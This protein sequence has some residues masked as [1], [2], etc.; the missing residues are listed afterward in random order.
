[1]IKAS[2]PHGAQFAAI[3]MSEFTVAAIAQQLSGGFTVRGR[4]QPWAIALNKAGPVLAEFAR[5]VLYLSREEM[6]QTASLPSPLRDRRVESVPG[7]PGSDWSHER[8]WRI[9]W[10]D[11][12]A[13]PGLNLIPG[14]VCS[15]IVGRSG[16]T[17]S[18]RGYH[19]T[20]IP[21]WL[22]TGRGLVDDGH[23]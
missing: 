21:R 5:P 16:W 9:C 3:C 18:G 4:Y 17:P 11:D 12:V 14:T 13:N 6:G 23:I 7:Q 8:E 22:W 15:I 19:P 2:I 20:P 10:G 1:V